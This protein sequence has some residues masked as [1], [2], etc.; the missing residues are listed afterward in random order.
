MMRDSSK[1]PLSFSKF[2]VPGLGKMDDGGRWRLGKCVFRLPYA[3]AL[4]AAGLIFCAVS[5]GAQTQ[6]SALW[7]AAGEKWDKA[8]LPDF[9]DAGYKKGRVPIPR[10]PVGVNVKDAGAKGDGKTDDVAAIRKAIAQC[11]PN[12]AVYFPNGIYALSDSIRIG[13]SGV[14]LRGQ[15]RDGTVLSFRKGLEQLYPRYNG[16]QSAWSWEGAML[17]FTGK[18]TEVGV[19]NLTVQFPDSLYM[20]HDFHERGYNG[21]GFESG[22]DNG[23]LRYIT[24][25]N[26]DLGIYIR[27][28]THISCLHWKL[29]FKGVRET[30]KIPTGPETGQ[31]VSGH[32]G[33]NCYAS[34]NLFHDFEITR[35]YFH[36]LSVEPDGAN[37]VNGA[38][39]NVFSQGKLPD[40]RLD[41][42]NS[43]FRTCDHNVWTDIDLGVGSDIYNSSG[44]LDPHRVM[45]SETFWNLK[46]QKSTGSDPDTSS[47][48]SVFVAVDRQNLRTQ[49]PLGHNM[50]LERIPTAAIS[51][52]NIYWAQMKLL[53]GVDP[54]ITDSTAGSAIRQPYGANAL[55]VPNP[56]HP[57]RGLGWNAA[58]RLTPWRRAD[59]IPVWIAPMPA[60]VPLPQR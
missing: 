24:I 7:G 16:S 2:P 44:A 17:L 23:W 39:W 42:H 10:F 34:H 40:G 43:L 30:E 8:R 4:A 20:G 46:G 19:E 26:A 52:R 12:S 33:V 48:N 28:S 49:G 22:V 1:S 27:A 56:L 32:H 15:S 21:I 51:P 53:Y 41:H 31:S 25:V 58:G 29:T 57:E 59:G 45:L 55:Q 47:A 38:R 11:P 14:V 35:D 60:A 9:T 37:G 18:I 54:S 5:I 50:Y 13:K 3:G 6:N 36:H